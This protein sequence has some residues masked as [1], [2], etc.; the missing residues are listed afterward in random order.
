ME[1]VAAVPATTAPDRPTSVAPPTSS[2]TALTG[3]RSSA[4]PVVAPNLTLYVSNQS[5]EHDPVGITVAIDGEVVVRDQFFVEGQHN[6]ITFELSVPPGRHEL[7]MATD[8]G[9][10]HTAE[11]EIPTDAHRWAVADYW[12]YGD[13]PSSFTFHIDDEPIYFQ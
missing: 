10:S 13:T 12:F 9:A 2:V 7:T 3:G 6:W 5:F 1:P 8:T 4:A 11:L